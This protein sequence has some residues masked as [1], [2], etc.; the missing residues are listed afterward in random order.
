MT[1]FILKLWLAK[2]NNN[3]NLKCTKKKVQK[4]VPWV[5]TVCLMHA[6]CRCADV[7]WLLIRKRTTT[8]TPLFSVLI[9]NWWTVRSRVFSTSP[10]LPLTVGKQYAVCHSFLVWTT[11]LLQRGLICNEP[12]KQS[13]MFGGGNNWKSAC[14]NVFVQCFSQHTRKMNTIT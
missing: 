12:S 13:V 14:V 6:L 10:Y 2:Y 1:R 8:T 4:E 7:I 9:I 11:S 3:E 5:F